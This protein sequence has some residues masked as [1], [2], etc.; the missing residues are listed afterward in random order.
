[1]FIG[2]EPGRAFWAGEH[3]GDS[4]LCDTEAKVRV[5]PSQED[6]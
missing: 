3:F 5:G 1:M 2:L 6:V 4:F